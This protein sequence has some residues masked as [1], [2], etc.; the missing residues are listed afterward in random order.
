[1]MIDWDSDK[2]HLLVNPS[3]SDNDQKR[4]QQILVQ[5]TDYP[6]HLWLS[7]SGTSVQKWVGLSKTAILSSA[8]AVNHYFQ[9]DSQDCWIQSLPFFHIGGIG[10]WA[11]A[12]LSGAKVEVFRHDTSTKWNPL[13]F[14]HFLIEKKGTLIA[15]VPTQLYDLVKLNCVAPPFLRHVIIGGGALFEGLYQKAIDLKWPVI[16]TYGMTETSSQIAVGKK[17]DMQLLPHIKAQVDNECLSFKGSSLFTTYAYIEREKVQFLDPK[18]DGWFKSGDRGALN[19]GSIEVFGRVDGLV[20]IGGEMVDLVKL[21]ELLQHVFLT[22]N[23]QIEAVLSTKPDHRLGAV[24]H[25]VVEQSPL[26]SE[27]TA[28]LV[29]H[30]NTLVLP[31]EKIRSVHYVDAIPRTPLGKVL[32]KNLKLII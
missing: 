18:E 27:Q 28:L 25:L 29:E 5:G 31:F 6:G 9:S 17:G 15:L 22:G 23:F 3:Y 32:T 16:S 2:S 21:E 30:Y 19:G 8:A 26:V 4:F 14:Y 10:I 12:F 11:R 24:V 20:K 7:T 13:E 1:M